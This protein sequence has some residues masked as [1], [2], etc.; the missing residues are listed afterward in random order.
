MRGSRF[1]K[2]LVA[3]LAVAACATLSAS[4]I[5]TGT[6]DIAGTI[7]VDNPGINGCVSFGGCITWTDPTAANADKADIGGTTGAISTIV[8]FSGNDAANISNMNN[9]PEIVG[10]A[11]FPPQTFMTFNNGG[12]TSTLLIN[13]ILAGIYPP[14]NQ[15]GS[16]AAAPPPVQDC[17]STGSLFSFVNNPTVI[18]GQVAQATATWF[19]GGVTS[20]GLLWSGNFTAQFSTPFQTVFQQLGTNGSVTNSYSATITLLPATSTPEPPASALMGLGVGLVGLAAVLRRRL[21][22]S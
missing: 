1:V 7:T 20:E 10:G 4:P 9:P 18:P 17:T 12:I 13:M 14:P 5:L 22:R 15:C 19:L 16:A 3:L 6:F 2:L 11:G 8:G 21:R